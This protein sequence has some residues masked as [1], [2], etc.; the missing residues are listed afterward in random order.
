L[1]KL[2]IV[3]GEAIPNRNWILLQLLCVS[4][5]GCYCGKFYK[6]DIRPQCCQRGGSNSIFAN[7]TQHL[8]Y[9]CF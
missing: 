4:S 1:W 6:P 8:R 3:A 2:V 5:H 7:V 9:D